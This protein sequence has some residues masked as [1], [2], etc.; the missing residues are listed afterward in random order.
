[1]NEITYRVALVTFTLGTPT[2]R[3]IVRLKSVAPLIVPAICKLTSRPA[4]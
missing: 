4:T 2:F 1:M 3:V